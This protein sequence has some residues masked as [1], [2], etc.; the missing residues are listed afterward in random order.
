MTIT[1][2]KVLRLDPVAC[3]G[4]RKQRRREAGKPASAFALDFGLSDPEFRREI[5][6]SLM[7]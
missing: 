1:R 7:H 5:E 4:L 6:I 3:G 2:W